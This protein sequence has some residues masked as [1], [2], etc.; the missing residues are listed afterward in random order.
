MTSNVSSSPLKQTFPL[1]IWTFTEGDGIESRLPFKIFSTLTETNFVKPKKSKYS[2]S[3]FKI[4]STLLLCHQNSPFKIKSTQSASDCAHMSGHHARDL[5]PSKHIFMRERAMGPK[6]WWNRIYFF[7]HQKSKTIDKILR[8]AEKIDQTRRTETFVG[9][10]QK[11]VLFLQQ[12]ADSNSK[13]DRY[14]LQHLNKCLVLLI[15]SGL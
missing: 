14:F 11:L 15:Y 3:E 9:M 1:I 5:P 8:I 10:L 6:Y 4:F 13:S 7:K 2:K 12:A